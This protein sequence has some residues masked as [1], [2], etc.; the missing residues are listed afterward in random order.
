[1]KTAIAARGTDADA[2]VDRHFGKCACFFICD[3][4]TGKYEILENPGK[5]M[6]GCVGEVIVRKLAE[7]QVGRVIA[8]DFGTKVQQ[9]LNLGQIQMIIHPDER[10]LVS[11]VI[12]LLKFKTK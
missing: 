5:G 10:V 8:G 2:E 11:D 7:H 9:F 3:E 6:R 12:E 1:M 4:E